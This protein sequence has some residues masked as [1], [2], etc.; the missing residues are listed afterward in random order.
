MITQIQCKTYADNY[1]LLGR[2]TEISMQRATIL[3]AIS[4]SWTILAG[5][6]GRL[7]AIEDEEK[8]N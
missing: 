1:Q 3:M 6:L 8:K 4:R 2:A 7:T 5:Q